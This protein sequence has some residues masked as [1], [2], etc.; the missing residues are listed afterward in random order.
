MAH[1]NPPGLP[2]E[3]GKIHEFANSIGAEEPLFHDEEAAKAAGL[4]SV[5]APPTYTSTQAFF[6]EKDAP[7][8]FKELG[9]DLRYVLHGGQEYYYERPI[10]AGDTLIAEPGETIASTKE[11]KRGGS[12]K[13]FDMY[14]NYKNQ[15]GELVLRVK[16][17]LL[18]TAGV[19]KE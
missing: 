11:G 14:T 1:I 19:V 3:R 17:T 18:Q 5:V 2:I 15:D 16:N 7:N 10:F 13:I 9:L 8:M 12:M 6:S 4:P